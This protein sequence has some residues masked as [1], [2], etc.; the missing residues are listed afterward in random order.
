MTSFLSY[1]VDKLFIGFGV[2]SPTTSTTQKAAAGMR[3]AGTIVRSPLEA[4]RERKERSDGDT[5]A[6]DVSS[7]PLSGLL[8]E[9]NQTV[10]LRPLALYLNK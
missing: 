2:T 10:F 3:R 1:F 8:V 5:R 6:A 7:P 4:R 9:V